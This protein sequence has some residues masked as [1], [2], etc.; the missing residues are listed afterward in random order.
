MAY[1]MGLGDARHKKSTTRVLFCV[2]PFFALQREGP[3]RV[4][5]LLSLHAGAA[6]AWAAHSLPPVTPAAK[7]TEPAV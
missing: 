1:F 4:R 2:F 5:S 3:L 6:G 7:G